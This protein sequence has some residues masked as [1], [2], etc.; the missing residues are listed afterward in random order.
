MIEDQVDD[1]DGDP[2]HSLFMDHNKSF[3]AL[4]CN[5]KFLEAVQQGN[6]GDITSGSRGGSAAE[7]MLRARPVYSSTICN[8]GYLN[9][10]TRQMRCCRP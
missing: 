2:V 7:V 1:R 5:E 9:G 8:R 4:I 10:F 3:V 6:V